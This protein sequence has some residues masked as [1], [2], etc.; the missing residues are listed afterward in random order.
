MTI[1]SMRTATN[2]QE[3]A[4]GKTEQQRRALRRL[5]RDLVAFT[6]TAVN[7]LAAAPRKAPQQKRP[8]L[9][10]RRANTLTDADLDVLVAD[11]GVDRW[12]AAAERATQPQLPL[13]AAE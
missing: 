2:G 9:L 8:R 13:V 11:I 3:P 7:D 1:V 5:L 6:G 4:G 10:Y 12:W